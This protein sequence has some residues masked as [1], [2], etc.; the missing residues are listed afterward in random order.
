MRG[1]HQNSEIKT[2]RDRNIQNEN[3]QEAN[4]AHGL[5]FAFCYFL[6]NL[7]TPCSSSFFLEHSTSIDM[8][9]G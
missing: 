5:F 7:A 9:D 2:E 4:F 1:A 3:E 8:F 6:I